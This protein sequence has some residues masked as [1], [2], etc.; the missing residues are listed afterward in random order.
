MAFEVVA[1]ALAPDN[2]RDWRGRK[3]RPTQSGGWAW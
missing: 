3:L 1:D 2:G